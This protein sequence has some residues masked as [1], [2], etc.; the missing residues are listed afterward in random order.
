[1]IEKLEEKH[2]TTKEYYRNSFL[3]VVE[4]LIT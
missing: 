3:K 1:M 4:D 2:I